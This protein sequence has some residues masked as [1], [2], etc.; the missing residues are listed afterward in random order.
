MTIE[1]AID[2]IS[3]VDICANAAE[4]ARDMAINA[5]RKEALENHSQ[6]LESSQT[7]EYC[8]GSQTPL[9]VD[10]DIPY[11]SFNRIRI[12]RDGAVME[13]ADGNYIR[14]KACPMCGRKL[15]EVVNG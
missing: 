4:T 3:R 1:E 14:I 7:C 6:A 15:D 9:P 5:L 8:D 11:G 10:C 13:D 12:E 2:I